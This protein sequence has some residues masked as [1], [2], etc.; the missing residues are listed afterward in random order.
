MKDK[1]REAAEEVKSEISEFAK[2]TAAKWEEAEDRI[3]AKAKANRFSTVEMVA[4]CLLSFS[5]GVVLSFA[6][7]AAMR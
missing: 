2:G 3:E 5:L 1:V 7:F 6:F 4:A